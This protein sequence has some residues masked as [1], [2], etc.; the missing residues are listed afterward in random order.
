MSVE[1]QYSSR[2]DDTAVREPI[3]RE[4]RGRQLPSRSGEH[5]L[6]LQVAQIFFAG[7]SHGTVLTIDEDAV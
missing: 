1:A 4:C 3:R 5:A 7:R 6:S 2:P